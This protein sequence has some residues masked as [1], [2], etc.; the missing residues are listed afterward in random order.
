L[1]PATMTMP[2][3]V[4]AANTPLLCKAPRYIDQN[5]G[6]ST[7]TVPLAQDPL[8]ILNEDEF[9]THRFDSTTD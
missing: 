9:K 1:W 8:M 3:E 7:E 4:A 5:S 6:S 2:L